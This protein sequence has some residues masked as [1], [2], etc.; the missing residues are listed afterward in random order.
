V[1][2]LAST[3]LRYLLED[4]IG[5]LDADDYRER[6]ELIKS[7]HSGKARYVGMR[8]DFAIFEWG[9]RELIGI[10]VSILPK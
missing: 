6:T 8:G 9:G 4:A 2:D 5:R 7:G 3:G 1:F 10:R